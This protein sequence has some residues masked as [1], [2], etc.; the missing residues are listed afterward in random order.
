MG[1]T[2][3]IE[4]GLPL[5]LIQLPSMDTKYIGLD[6]VLILIPRYNLYLTVRIW[7]Q[8]DKSS[9]ADMIPFLVFPLSA[10]LLQRLVAIHMR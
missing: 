7:C 4:Y 9:S 8:N 10:K 1:K 3:F 2:K 5:A 6:L